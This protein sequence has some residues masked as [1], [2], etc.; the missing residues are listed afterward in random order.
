MDRKTRTILTK[1]RTLHPESAV[2]K[3][4]IPR[5]ESG[6]GVINLA[7]LHHK[8]TH[9]LQQYFLNKKD[10]AP[11]YTEV[12]AADQNYTPLCLSQPTHT[13]AKQFYGSHLNGFSMDYVHKIK[14]LLRKTT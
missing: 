13:E 3:L 14:L 7:S 2:E 5:E 11:L 1:H 6:R 4:T 12:C 8:L 10:A 9:Y